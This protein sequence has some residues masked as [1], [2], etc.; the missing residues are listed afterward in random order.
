M[1]S[2]AV[3]EQT[4]ISETG[5]R[6]PERGFTLI[7]ILVVVLILG[8]TLGFAVLSFGDFGAA[9]RVVMQ[10]EQF[11]NALRLVEQRA[12]LE[13]R[14][15]GVRLNN[16]AWQVLTFDPVKGWQPGPR[17]NFFREHV[18]SGNTLVSVQKA[19]NAEPSKPRIIFLPTGNITPFLINFGLAEQ[20]PIAS[21]EGKANG[22]ILLH[23][24][25]GGA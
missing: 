19:L 16:R 1:V 5:M 22:T 20:P 9:R 15:L 2:Q 10:A 8:I 6:P 11:A 21:V 24:I 13:T 17:N 4:R 7:E 23:A 3:R 12:I 14:T 25:R 18:F